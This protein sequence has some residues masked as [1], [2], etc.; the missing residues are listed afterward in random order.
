MTTHLFI[1]LPDVGLEAADVV[2]LPLPYEGTVSY[3]KGTSLGPAAILHASS[4]NE[5]WD[6]EVDFD[7]D[8]LAYHI[9]APVVPG[10][11]QQPGDY[12]E[13]VAA[14][15]RRLRSDDRLLIGIGGEHSVTFPLICAQTDADDFSDITV[16]QIDAHTDLRSEY[17]GSNFSHA[18]VMHRVVESGAK[19]IAIGIRSAERNEFSYGRT[20]GRVETFFAQQLAGNPDRERQLIERLRLLSGNVYLTIDVDGLDVSLCPATG[21]PQPGGLTWWQ[22]LRYLR[23]MLDE[24]KNIRLIG[25][26][27][28][29]TVP[30]PDS[31]VNEFTSA[32]LLGKLLAYHFAQRCP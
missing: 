17:E 5:L 31:R 22:A 14:E 23:V 25:C 3:G 15:A 1:D 9:A 6:E 10:D 13:C 2:V 19:L 30:Q 18:C 27:V 26:D 12:L 7:L 21:T 32:R 24:N 20:S 28:V 4:Q 11:A 8:R 29:E 16:V